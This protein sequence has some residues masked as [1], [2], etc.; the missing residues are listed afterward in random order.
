MD[1]RDASFKKFPCIT[2]QYNRQIQNNDSFCWR[3]TVIF[4]AFTTDAPLSNADTNANRLMLIYWIFTLL[5][6]ATRHAT[7]FHCFT[8]GV[9]ILDRAGM[10]YSG[11]TTAVRVYASKCGLMRITYETFMFDNFFFLSFSVQK[12]Y[13]IDRVIFIYKI[14]NKKK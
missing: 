4:E 3:G 1:G 14:R 11:V 7:Y 12:G 2:F 8:P 6:D 10:D 5:L 9:S 13:V